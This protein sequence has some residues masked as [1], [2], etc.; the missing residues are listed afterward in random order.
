MGELT[1][2]VVASSSRGNCYL[3]YNPDE[4]LIIEAGVPF[5]ELNRLLFFDLKNVVGCVVSHEHGDHACRMDEYLK[6]GITCRASAGTIRNVKYTSKRL[7]LII[8]HGV[9]CKVGNFSVLPFNTEH[10]AEEPVG[11][12]VYHPS[13]GTMLFATDTYYLRYK[14]PGLNHILIECNYQR[15]ILDANFEN[16][17]I[18]VTRR[19]RTLLSHMEIETCIE[20]L[21][22]ND[23]SAV[24][25]VVLLHLSDQNSNER[26]FVKRI[27]EETRRFTTSATPGLSIT[28]SK[29]AF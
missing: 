5:K 11:F 26:E 23:L 6:Y 10:D 29:E 28:L 18:D 4:C 14:F 16:G 25:N 15:S 2:Y 3:L 9:S 17:K 21:R 13:M 20:A 7:P 1:L 22:A 8:E 24:N 12:L 27:S 19:N